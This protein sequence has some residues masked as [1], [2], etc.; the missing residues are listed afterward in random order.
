MQLFPLLMVTGT[1][2]GGYS[3]DENEISLVL[4]MTSVAELIYQ[5]TN[6]TGR[7]ATSVYTYYSKVIIQ[8]HNNLV[9]DAIWLIIC[10]VI[11]CAHYL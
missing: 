1:Q 7:K 5:V 9:V 4:S 6:Y 11:L 8:Y 10:N 2:H 3:L